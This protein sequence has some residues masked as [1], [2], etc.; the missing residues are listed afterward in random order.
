MSTNAQFA[1]TEPIEFLSESAP[2]VVEQ[3]TVEG[4]DLEIVNYAHLAS[5]PATQTDP[6]GPTFDYGTRFYA[7][8]RG[9]PVRPL[10]YSFYLV[11]GPVYD[12]ARDRKPTHLAGDVRG[13][14]RVASAVNESQEIG[15]GPTA[16]AAITSARNALKLREVYRTLG[17][18]AEAN[19]RTVS[20]DEF[21]ALDADAAIERG[22]LVVIHSH[23]RMRLGVAYHVTSTGTVKA[24]IA[25]PTGGYAQGASAKLGTTARL[26]RK[27][28]TPVAV[29]ATPAPVQGGRSATDR[30]M[31]DAADTAAAAQL[32]AL[33]QAAKSSDAKAPADTDPNTLGQLEDAGFITPTRTITNRGLDHL[34]ANGRFV[35]TVTEVPDVDGTPVRVGDVVECVGAI[36][37][38][39]TGKRGLVVRVSRDDV[40]G[41]AGVEIKWPERGVSRTSR[42]ANRV[43][44]VP[45]G[46]GVVTEVLDGNG[47][48]VEVPE[49][50]AGDELRA[51]R[52][53]MAG[54]V[55]AR[56]CPH[57]I[58]TS[59]DDAGCVRCEQ[60]TCRPGAP[61]VGCL[62][63][64][65]PPI[66]MDAPAP[67]VDADQADRDELDAHDMRAELARGDAS[68]FGGVV[69][70]LRAEHGADD[71]V[72]RDAAILDA[73]RERQGDDVLDAVFARAADMSEVLEAAGRPDADDVA[74]LLAETEKDRRCD[75]REEALLAI[76]HCAAG[77]KLTGEALAAFDRGDYVA[78]LDLARRQ[79]EVQAGEEVTYQAESR[80]ALG[81]LLT[82]AGFATT[83]VSK[84]GWVHRDGGVVVELH[85]NGP[86][87]VSYQA[88]HAAVDGED[89][90]TAYV[91][92][93]MWQP[94]VVRDVAVA[95]TLLPRPGVAPAGERVGHVTR[96]LERDAVGH[97]AWECWECGDDGSGYES[98]AEV[99]EAAQAHGPLAADSV[100]PYDVDDLGD[101]LVEHDGLAVNEH[102]VQL[103][104]LPGV[105]WFESYDSGSWRFDGESMSDLGADAAKEA[106]AWAADHLGRGDYDVVPV[107]VSRWVHHTDRY[108]NWWTP[109][110]V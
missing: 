66:D 84:T 21:H 29:E 31:L 3:V 93:P 104:T 90:G 36:N 22:D 71:D 30:R 37:A 74:E 100:R 34:T 44:L 102:G 47:D 95:L 19:I 110:C 16:K 27:A 91:T 96:V 39:L 72:E 99:L 45:E 41:S 77:G 14:W 4:V 12:F 23:G 79:R 103:R 5:R 87:A 105:L 92:M 109:V 67:A 52:L 60:A 8:E 18:V 40:V 46:N 20:G 94:E 26:F 85:E 58:A 69:G 80:V 38:V 28:A 86:V 55:P 33:D 15:E 63:T 59:E 75:R 6:A 32:D 89:A 2:C 9:A 54:R 106:Q 13:I 76:G 97:W 78:A 24:L 25:T 48:R 53:F 57:Y 65:P 51:F 11:D 81:A 43:R 83:W 62:A 73:A 49:G 50:L 10:S 35:K 107:T 64:L 56:K 68:A 98:A 42:A 7:I 88:V 70:S 61:V 17:P 108:G 101:E 1:T 82:A